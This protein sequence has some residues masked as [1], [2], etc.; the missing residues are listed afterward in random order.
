MTN[1]IILILFVMSFF[2]PI[3][4]DIFV[5]KKERYS[6]AILLVI[7][8]IFLLSFFINTEVEGG[9]LKIFIYVMPIIFILYIFS[10]IY[11]VKIIIFLIK[12][13]LDK[14]KY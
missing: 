1:L 13:L 5:L 6:I 7:I 11:F 9:Y 4:Y 10:F 12:K 8:Y 14:K 2:I 3:I